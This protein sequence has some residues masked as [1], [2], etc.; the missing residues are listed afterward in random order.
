ML[1]FPRMGAALAVALS[2]ASIGGAVAPVTRTGRYL[3]FTGGERF[4]I[5]GI[6]YQ[7]QGKYHRR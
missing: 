5:K 1:S 7:P 3:Y 6:A 2:L 4:Y